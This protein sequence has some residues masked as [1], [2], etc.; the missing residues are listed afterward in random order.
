ME[1]ISPWSAD[2]VWGVP[3]IVLT[4]MFHVSGLG[5]IR[6]N[7]DRRMQYICRRQVLS[8]GVVTLSITCL[9]VVEVS[10]WATMFLLLQAVPDRQTA[11]LYSLNALT[12]FGHTDVKLERQ[13]QLLGAMESL[14]GWIL[15]GLSTAY[16]FVLIQRIWSRDAQAYGA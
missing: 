1:N 6:R 13:W 11:A 16:L 15:F 10:L 8:I 4:V 9:H 5:V 7:T 14:N 12:A 3:L 2:W